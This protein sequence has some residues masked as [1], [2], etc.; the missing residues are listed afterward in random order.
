MGKTHLLDLSLS[1]LIFFKTPRRHVWQQWDFRKFPNFC[2]TRKTFFDEPFFKLTWGRWLQFLLNTY[3]W[4][5]DVCFSNGWPWPFA[6][7]SPKAVLPMTCAVSR[8]SESSRFLSQAPF[9]TS[10]L[11]AILFMFTFVTP[12]LSGNGGSLSLQR[13]TELW[14]LR[15]LYDNMMSLTKRSD[16]PH[17]ISPSLVPWRSADKSF[18]RRISASQIRADV[19]KERFYGTRLWRT[20]SE[21]YRKRGLLQNQFSWNK[22]AITQLASIPGTFFYSAVPLC[23]PCLTNTLI[24][25]VI[26]IQLTSSLLLCRQSDFHECHA[27][28]KPLFIFCWLCVYFANIFQASAWQNVSRGFLFWIPAVINVLVIKKP[29]DK[30]LIYVLHSKH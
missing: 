30:I 6:R 18:R 20:R 17:K 21:Q 7:L 22:R 11:P 26:G 14:S 27:D 9:S 5:P 15:E 16:T 10:N 29:F 12:Q 2:C 19:R 8:M 13:G 28:S 25:S 23:F 3:T 4:G 1:S 24:T